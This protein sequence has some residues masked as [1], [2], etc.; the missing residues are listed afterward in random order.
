METVREKLIKDIFNMYIKNYHEEYELF[1]KQTEER[2]N[3]LADQKFGRFSIKINNR[4]TYDD[5]IR[6]SFTFPTRLYNALSVLDGVEE[7]RFGEKKGEFKW[8]AKAYP[9]F[10]LSKKY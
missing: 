7:E 8:I 5:E 2:R 9:E 10:L 3:K 4:H 1:K 6:M